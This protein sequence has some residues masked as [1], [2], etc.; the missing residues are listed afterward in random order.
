MKWNLTDVEIFKVI[1]HL[2][3]KGWMFRR[4]DMIFRNG[5]LALNMTNHGQVLMLSQKLQPAQNGPQRESR[6]VQS[7]IMFR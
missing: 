3:L 7:R 4:K 5:I 6:V 1:N 2:R